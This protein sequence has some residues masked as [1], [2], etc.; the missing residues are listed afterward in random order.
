M[1]I[2]SDPT[3]SV[4]VGVRDR[5]NNYRTTSAS[6][7][8]SNTLANIIAEVE[9]SLIPAVQGAS[10][11]VVVAYTISLGGFDYEAPQAAETSDVE[12]KGVF[13]FR[14]LNGQTMKVEIPSIK[15]T[16]VVDGTNV[17]NIADPLVLAVENA[18]LTAGLDGLAAVT[19]I[20][21]ALASREGIPHKIHRRSSK[22]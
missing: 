19:A 12:R 13:Q 8:S 17:L 22:G 2:V 5:D 18:Y 20:G 10:D 6:Y 3:Y 11:G 7:P 1:A 9:G 4:T 14:A 21:S 16:L 15:N